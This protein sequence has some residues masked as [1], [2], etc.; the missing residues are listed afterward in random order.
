MIA[1]LLSTGVLNVAA[2]NEAIAIHPLIAEPSAVP[3]WRRLLE[4]PLRGAQAYQTDKADVLA[5]LAAQAFVEPGEILHVA[6][7]RSGWNR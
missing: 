2:A 5:A 4:W 1:D 3:S 7:A 6:G